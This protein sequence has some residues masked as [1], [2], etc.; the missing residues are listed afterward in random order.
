[1][2]YKTIFEVFECDKPEELSRKFIDYKIAR[3]FKGGESAVRGTVAEANGILVSE[4]EYGD[5]EIAGDLIRLKAEPEG[6]ALAV[7]VTGIDPRTGVRRK[8]WLVGAKVRE[9]YR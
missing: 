7:R 3:Q 9:E 2:N 1:M 5:P 6:S 8:V 4:T